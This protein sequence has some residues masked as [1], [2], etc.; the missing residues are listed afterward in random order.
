MKRLRFA[1]LVLGVLLLPCPGSH[2]QQP[3]PLWE[4]YKKRFVDDQGRVIDRSAN[5]RTTSEGQAYAMFFS[6]V[7]NDRGRF[8]KLLNWTEQNLASGDL[9][10][11]L[12]AWNWGKTSSGEWKVIDENSASDADVWMVYC[13]IEAGRLWHQPRY[14]KLGRTMALRVAKQEVVLVNGLGTTLAPGPNGFHPD[15]ETW[16]VNPSYMPLPVIVFLAKVMPHEAWSSV[17]SSMPA[18]TG[19]DVSHRFAMDWVAAG[20]G[21]IHPCLAPRQPSSG[22]R[23]PQISGSYD[24]IRVY[25]WLGM[26]DA[27]TPGLKKYLLQTSGMSTYL[28]SAVTPPL[29]VDVDGKVIRADAPPGFSA[30]VIPYLSSAGLK[31][32][33]T[34]QRDRLAATRDPSTGLYGRTAEYYDQNLALFSTAWSERRFR[35][36]HDGSLH[37]SWR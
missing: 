17:L 25:L 24:A 21:G 30:A 14:E 26:A 7:D 18:L 8:D 9:T 19:G 10:L 22:L 11:H 37:V 34:A 6:L 12:P 15:Q 32:Q 1:G 29:E 23:E 31:A 5:D 35:F 27:G 36:E 13:L 28:Q 20:S 4:S 16:I 33:A 2:A 3:W